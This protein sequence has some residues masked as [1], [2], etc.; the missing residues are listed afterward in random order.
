MLSPTRAPMLQA[1][2]DATRRVPAGMGVSP[3]EPRRTKAPVCMRRPVSHPSK[4][5]WPTASSKLSDTVLPAREHCTVTH[6]AT[7]QIFG[8]C[9]LLG[10][11]F[12][13]RLKDLKDQKLYRVDPDGSYGE[14]G[15]AAPKFSCRMHGMKLSKTLLGGFARVIL[16][17]GVAFAALSNATNTLLAN[18]ASQSEDLNRGKVPNCNGAA[19]RPEKFIPSH[20][21]LAARSGANALLFQDPLDGDPPQRTG[22][23]EAIK[24]PQSRSYLV[25]RCYYFFG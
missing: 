24:R 22:L 13:P 11:S 21:P 3:C 15:A 10:Y 19:I 20:L 1:G 16:S 17:S 7:D 5:T 9:H 4:K 14:A 23:K 25:S 2:T 12:R 6:G 18:E 8:L